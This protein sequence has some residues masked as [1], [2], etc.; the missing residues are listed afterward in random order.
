MEFQAL[1]PH[2][3]FQLRLLGKIVEPPKLS[4]DEDHVKNGA[5]YPEISAHLG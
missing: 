1:P 2:F 3:T 4:I 5:P